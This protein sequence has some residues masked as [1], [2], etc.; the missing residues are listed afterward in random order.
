M[1]VLTIELL[2]DWLLASKKTVVLTGAGMSTESGIPDFR[3]QT[4]LWRG[5]DP[6]MV[7]SMEVLQENYP[8]FR[9]FYQTRVES[10]ASCKPHKGHEILANWQQHGL[11]SLI[12]TQNVDG[13]HQTA[14]ATNIQELHG[15]ITT[16]RCMNCHKPSEWEAFYR[17]EVCASCSSNLRP[18]VVL[19]GELLPDEAWRVSMETIEQ[20]DL[21]LV[22]GTSLEV[23]PV[24]QLPAMTKGKLVYMNLETPN[25]YDF[26]LM[27]QGKAGEL[28]VQVNQLIANSL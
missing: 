14:G 27:L 15:N 13:F 9:E 11:V 3:S 12:A 22:I 28:L 4:G 16:F 8:L 18:N 25:G 2:K 1:R 6:R 23:Y 26:D 24:N 20:A 7:A 10:L 19:F 5:I 21:V 17:E